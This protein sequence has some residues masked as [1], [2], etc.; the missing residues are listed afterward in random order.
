[1]N[2]KEVIE[3]L[4]MWTSCLLFSSIV[5]SLA[6]VMSFKDNRMLSSLIGSTLIWMV[7][8]G[9]GLIS[10]WFRERV[11]L[12]AAWFIIAQMVP[13]L[14]F[15]IAIAAR[16]LSNQVTLPS[17]IFRSGWILDLSMMTFFIVMYELTIVFFL[18]FG[19]YQIRRMSPQALANFRGQPISTVGLK[20]DA[21]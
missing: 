9:L 4:L 8:A 10:I 3:W 5:Y 13:I 18:L 19:E 12:G 1:M 17:I 7:G 2:R 11:I 15:G 14:P 21:N 6:F 20:E 16:V